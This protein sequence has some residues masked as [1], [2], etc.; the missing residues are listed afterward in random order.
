MTQFDL[1]AARTGGI[2]KA[3]CQCRM[4]SGHGRCR[5]LR[6]YLYASGM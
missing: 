1:V 5:T 4:E 6:R 2:G 3:M